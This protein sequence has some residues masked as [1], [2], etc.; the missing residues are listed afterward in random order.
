MA[1]MKYGELEEYMMTEPLSITIS[2]IGYISRNPTNR[3][4]HNLLS[5]FSGGLSGGLNNYQ[6]IPIGNTY[7]VS[8]RGFMAQA[9]LGQWAS[10]VKF[11]RPDTL[12]I[13]NQNDKYVIWYDTLYKDTVDP[14]FFFPGTALSMGFKYRLLN[15]SVGYSLGYQWEEIILDDIQR[16]SDKKMITV[17]FDN[18]WWFHEVMVESDL[19]TDIFLTPSL[20]A[21]FKFPF[22]PTLRTKWHV[23]QFGLQ[24]R[25]RPVNWKKRHG[26]E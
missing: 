8:Y 2:A 1:K 13:Y 12:H 15:Y 23:L 21:K 14:A 7:Q 19:F 16:V 10:G 18:N 26:Y 24:I 6:G 22:G 4:F 9:E 11:R 17:I 5:S 25:L 20:Y 3:T